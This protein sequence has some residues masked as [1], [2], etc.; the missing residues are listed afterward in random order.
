MRKRVCIGGWLF[1]FLAISCVE[2]SPLHEETE[3][4][5]IPVQF[6][7]SLE[8]GAVATKANVNILTELQ[9]GQDVSDRFRGLVDIRTLPFG[10]EGKVR[11]SDE[12]LWDGRYLPAIS[13][14]ADDDYQEKDATGA[15][16]GNYHNGLIRNN[17]AH[18]YP[19]G[20]VT[21]PRG[22]ASMLVYGKAALADREGWTEQERKHSNGSLIESE[23]T[24]EAASITF[25]PDPIY[26]SEAN[27]MAFN[28]AQALSYIVYDVNDLHPIRTAPVSFYY[29]NGQTGTVTVQWDADIA[30]VSLRECFNWFTGYGQ[31]MSS[32]GY[33][34]EYMLTALYGRLTSLAAEFGSETAPTPYVHTDNGRE[35]ETFT[36]AAHEMPL[37]A[38][39]LYQNL[40]N[41]I[42]DRFE[43]N[44]SLVLDRETGKVSLGGLLHDFPLNFGLPAG[45]SVIRWKGST[46]VPVIYGDF[47]RIASIGRFCYMPR[48]YYFVNTTISTAIDEEVCQV[49]TSSTQS[50]RDILSHY[51]KGKKVV[52]DTKAVALDYPLDYACSMLVANVRSTVT[53]L[54]DND[55]NNRTNIRV[56]DNVLPVTGIIIGSQFEQ[57]FSFAPKSG[58]DE[59]YLYDNQIEGIYLK[60]Y[61][62]STPSLPDFRTLVLPTPE[63][64]D[65]YFY[66]EFRNDSGQSFTGADGVILPG[67]HFYLAGKL[68][69]PEGTES[70][71]IFTQD[72]YTSVSCVVSS[73]E[74]AFL[75]VP[76][77]ETQQLRLGVKTNIDW[78]M[79]TP[80]TLILE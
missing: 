5:A 29:G 44:A 12:A 11:T 37:T 17:N 25:S 9:T 73:L 16:T 59:Y 32:A 39:V 30:N 54:P 3:G 13:S 47:D 6:A 60:K 2:Q 56:E 55:G 15:W 46:F 34:V 57:D 20:S 53:E 1:L 8:S 21:L 71:R 65:V 79:S 64:D 50:W 48:L 70:P 63:Q 26:T 76:E 24:R 72:H 22:T 7:L 69:F 77:L 45:A 49:Y 42:L 66:L 23:W 18:L 36:D 75:C 19:N 52:G 51:G 74:N 78:I 10:R 41:V 38:E 31:I 4:G 33:N 35:Y 67:S 68:E 62:D 40:C 14:H 58:V 28:I 43:T 61:P 27:G 80:R